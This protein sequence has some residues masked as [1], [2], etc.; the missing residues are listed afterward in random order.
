MRRVYASPGF[1]L[2][3]LSLALIALAAVWISN[4]QT[5]ADRVAAV[6]LAHAGVTAN[7]GWQP[8]TTRNYDVQ[9]ALVPAGCF[10]MGS[11]PEQLAFAQASCDKYF[12]IYGCKVSFEDETPAHEVCFDQ[13]FWIDVTEVTNDAYGGAYEGENWRSRRWPRETVTWAEAAAHCAGRGARLP[14]EAEW[15][16]AARGPDSLIYPWGDE[17]IRENVLWFS[18]VLQPSGSFPDGASWVGALDM[19]GSAAEWVDGW[20][21]PYSLGS[22]AAGDERVTRGGDWFAHASYELRSASRFARDPEFASTAVGFRCAAD[23]DAP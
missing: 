17:F 2:A 7:A 3:I 5:E 4:A 9:M 16:Y 6:A 14:T 8:F 10:R 15:E 20:Y 18:L 19:S 21:A 22:S 11:T 1:W 13:P 12:N 23:V